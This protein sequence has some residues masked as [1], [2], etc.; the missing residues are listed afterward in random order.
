MSGPD[1]IDERFDD[2]VREL[3]SGE[4]TASP[5]L[6]ERVRAIA[7]QW[8]EPR[9]AARSGWSRRRRVTLVL[10]P[11]AAA[12]AVAV[13][14]GV[15]GSGTT[16]KQSAGKAHTPASLPSAGYPSP[17]ARKALAPRSAAG[18]VQTGAAPAPSG[19]RAQIYVADLQL[20]VSD[21]SATTKPAIR[22]TRAWGGYLVT[23]DYGSGGRSGSAYL[24]LRVPIA[25]VQT[26]VAKLSS[27][28]TIANEHVSIQDVQGQL[29]QRYA[30]MQDVK[31][32][33]AKLRADLAQPDLTA[34]QRAFFTAALAERQA[35]LAALEQQQQAQKTRTS[36]ATITLDLRTK[37]AAVVVPSKPGRIGQAL[38]EIGRVLVTE[39]EILLYVL[40]VGAPF[41]LL[42]LL[43]WG[44]RRTL[45]RRSEE[46]LLAR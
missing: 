37:Q 7:T 4:V 44:G 46:Q 3:R 1:V 29:N 6:R 9:A 36:F 39:A 26:A 22:L 33:I 28:G 41:V 24:V 12:L 10:V 14:V 23:V 34:S 11:V 30:R 42:A 45:R 5:E 38:H 20:R 15:F 18:Q 21:L 31:A 40:L 27:L 32:R 2:L 43:L 16:S 17:A 35:Q 19:S 25:V 8:D 13:G